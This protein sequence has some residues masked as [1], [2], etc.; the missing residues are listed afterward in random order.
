MLLAVAECCLDAKLSHQLFCGTYE[1]A[2]AE[3]QRA[4]Q[5]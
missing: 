1:S 3:I 5:K 2:K 4:L